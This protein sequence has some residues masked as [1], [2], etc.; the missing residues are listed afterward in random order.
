MRLSR[1]NLAILVAGTSQAICEPVQR[2]NPISY[3]PCKVDWSNT[4]PND[5]WRGKGKRCKP[6]GR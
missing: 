5:N 1:I 2:I 3:A 4:H 6:R